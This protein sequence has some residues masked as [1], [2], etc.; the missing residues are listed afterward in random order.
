MEIR[1]VEFNMNI[2]P[3]LDFQCLKISDLIGG[4]TRPTIVRLYKS[5]SN[6][7]ELEKLIYK[8]LNGPRI[9]Y[10]KWYA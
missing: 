4:A 8:P 10:K 3:K 6:S 1:A 9:K 2:I 5:S 7:S